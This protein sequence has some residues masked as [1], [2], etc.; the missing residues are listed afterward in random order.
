M[1]KEADIAFPPFGENRQNI[2]NIDDLSQKHL[3]LKVADYEKMALKIEKIGLHMKTGAEGAKNFALLFYIFRIFA[4]FGYF[5]SI[6]W[7]FSAKF[8]EKYR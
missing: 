8:P 7:H 3:C 2:V 6:F 4:I 5:W 1:G